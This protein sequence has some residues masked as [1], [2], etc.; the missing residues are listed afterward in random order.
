[1]FYIICILRKGEF[2]PF[3]KKQNF[4]YE[5]GTMF[6]QFAILATVIPFKCT[7]FFVKTALSQALFGFAFNLVSSA[8]FC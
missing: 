7:K 3:S 5:P 1:M 4:K 8:L 2:V 6:I